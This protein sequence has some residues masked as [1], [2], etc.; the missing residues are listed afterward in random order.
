MAVGDVSS[1]LSRSVFGTTGTSGNRTL[2]KDDFLKLLVSQMRNQNPLDPLKDGEFVAQMSQFS[3]VEGIQQL[4]ASFAEML[5]LQQM[6]QG[7]N[8]IGKTIVYEKTGSTVPG[9]GLVE[10][11]KMDNGKL[12]LV[13][14]GRAV[15]LSQVRSIEKT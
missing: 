15:S 9:R 2:G 6:T 8:L 3:T 12:S 4:N 5:L 1:V 10:G 13:V 7:A 14:E 11:V